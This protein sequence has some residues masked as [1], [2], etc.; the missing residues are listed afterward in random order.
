MPTY[1]QMIKTSYNYS[2]IEM[3]DSTVLYIEISSTVYYLCI[4]NKKAI[5]QLNYTLNQ[6]TH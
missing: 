3:Q 2:V 4:I 5:L 6:Q 1:T